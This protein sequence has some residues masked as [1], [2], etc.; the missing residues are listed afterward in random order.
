MS[1]FIGKNAFD[2]IDFVIKHMDGISEFV[3]VIRA[4]APP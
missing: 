3:V 2:Y 1:N 4:H